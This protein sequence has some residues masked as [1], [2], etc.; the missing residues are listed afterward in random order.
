MIKL[1][2]SLFP[3]VTLE[4][5]GSIDQPAIR[6][7]AAAWWKCAARRSRRA[8]F[9]LLAD[10][11]AVDWWPRE[12]QF[13]RRLSPIV[14]DPAAAWKVTVTAARR[15]CRRW[16]LAGQAGSNARRG[17][18][19]ASSS[20][21]GDLQRLLMPEDWEGFRCGRI[22]RADPAAAARRRAAAGDRR[23]FRADL[24]RDKAARADAQR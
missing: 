20:R 11:S 14:D 21:I 13:R 7:P 24:A 1:L 16:N 4:P 2:R 18:C 10:I 12:P 5:A 17:T 3:A 9:I 6:V 22:S 8:R 19:S 15:G 23:E